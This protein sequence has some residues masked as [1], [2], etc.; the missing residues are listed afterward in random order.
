MEGK[1]SQ[2]VQTE[3]SEQLL[4]ALTFSILR[5]GISDF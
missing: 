4:D 1:V 5:G 3:I 2:L